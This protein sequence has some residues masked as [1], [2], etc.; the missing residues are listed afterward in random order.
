M[1]DPLQRRALAEAHGPF[2]LDRRIDQGFPPERGDDARMPGRD[3]VEELAREIRDR[4]RGDGADRMIHLAQDEDVHVANVAGQEERHHL[5][6]SVLELLVATGPTGQDQVDILRFL[7]FTDDIDA[8]CKM[9]D[10][11]S[12]CTIENDVID[13]RKPYELLQFTD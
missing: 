8:R 2:A 9:P 13:R 4:H 11:L 12:R 10:P 6:P 7:A 1:S 5:A 3:L